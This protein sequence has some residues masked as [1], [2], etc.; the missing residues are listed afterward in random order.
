[1]KNKHLL[2]KK[3]PAYTCQTLSRPSAAAPFVPI[4]LASLGID[5]P[6]QLQLSADQDQ[7]VQAYLDVEEYTF[8][9]EALHSWMTESTMDKKKLRAMIAEHTRLLEDAQKRLADLK[10]H[11]S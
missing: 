11:I 5:E 4:T 7:L 6:E 9:L 1:M 2:S 10:G 3:R 8:E